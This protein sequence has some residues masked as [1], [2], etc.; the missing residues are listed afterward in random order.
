MDNEKIIFNEKAFQNHL[1]SLYNRRKFFV[2]NILV[3]F[4]LSFIFT[5][6]LPKTFKSSAVL[7]PP[8]TQSDF[9]FSSSLSASLSNL[10]MGPISDFLVEE[11]DETKLVIAILKS[12]TMMVNVINKFNLIDFYNV[13]NIDEA[14]EKIEDDVEIEVDEEGTIRISCIL[15]TSWFHHH[16]E[17]GFVRLLVS[18]MANFFVSNLDLI[19][20]DLKSQK[21]SFYKDFIE[22]RYEENVIDL[23]TAENNLKSFQEKYKMVSLEEQALAS[24]ELAAGIETQLL[25]VEI[26]Y[27]IA[28]KSLDSNHH[29]IDYLKK[30]IDE[31]KNQL[32]KINYGDDIEESDY[33][34]VISD[35]PDLAFKLE[36]L[37]RDVLIQ[38]TLHTLLTQEYEQAKINVM[39]DTPTIQVL[40]NAPV[41]SIKYGPKRLL[42]ILSTIF[43]SCFLV[44]FY[45]LFLED[46]FYFRK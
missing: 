28:N 9:N 43:S 33:F 39:K 27:G 40:D 45:I 30:Q 20:K 36:G 31:L 23:H 3:T 38:N 37:M 2:Y 13:R 5:F 10:P 11:D 17:E 16:E 1:I 44:I 12:R 21:A 32:R 29:Q 35:V 4:S 24:I 15:S 46:K 6:F 25:G 42:I 18:D 22:K 26:E 14:F 8:K 41:P 7:M 34:P 19:N